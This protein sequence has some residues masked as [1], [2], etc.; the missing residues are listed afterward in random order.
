MTKQIDPRAERLIKIALPILQGLLAS[1]QF[2]T[3][4]SNQDFPTSVRK[5]FGPDWKADGF[6]CRFPAS[7][8][9]E[10]ID[11]AIELSDQAAIHIEI[12]DMNAKLK[13]TDATQN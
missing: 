1:G 2:T 10:A 8:V 9:L 13:E 6:A 12:D 5:D 4:G 11:L 7:A 3:P